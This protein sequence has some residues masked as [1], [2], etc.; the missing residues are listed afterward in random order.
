MFNNFV[1]S[2]DKKEANKISEETAKSVEN[3][4]ASHV[5]FRKQNINKKPKTNDDTSNV[6]VCD[7]TIS[8]ITPHNQSVPKNI[9]KR[10]T[11]GE[12]ALH[13]AC[14]KV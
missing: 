4:H 14:S 5:N 13:R 12:T 3:S 10:N 6:S 11:K 8:R 7:S 9:N 1:L 2:L